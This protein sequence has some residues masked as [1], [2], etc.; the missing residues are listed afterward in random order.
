MNGKKFSITKL[1]SFFK[2]MTEIEKRIEEIAPL[3]TDITSCED[4]TGF[5]YD[6][7]GSICIRVYSSDCGNDAYWFPID[8]LT[9]DDE[10]I[11]EWEKKKSELAR[12]RREQER[13]R[14][15]QEELKDKK[16]QERKE[17]REYE[18]L[19]RKFEAQYKKQN[20]GD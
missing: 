4:I 6:E 20:I 3:C 18:R 2:D 19:K 1:K 12:K 8:Y 11:R 17:R 9:M 14:R 15:E 10:K 16:E 13:K 7:A 5:S